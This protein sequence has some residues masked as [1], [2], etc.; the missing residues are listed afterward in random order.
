M[1]N[2]NYQRKHLRGSSPHQEMKQGFDNWVR[3]L[4]STPLTRSIEQAPEDSLTPLCGIEQRG[5]QRMKLTTQE[6]VS[7]QQSDDEARWQDDGGESR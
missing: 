6:S 2:N 7:R 1:K 5:N 4:R 3:G